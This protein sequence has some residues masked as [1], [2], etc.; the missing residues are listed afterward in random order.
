MYRKPLL[1]LG[2]SLLL[3]FLSRLASHAQGRPLVIESVVPL[4]F[5]TGDTIKIRGT[6][7]GNNPDNLC[8]KVN[9]GNG[10]AIPLMAVE[11]TDTEVLAVVGPVR[12]DTPG[13]I[14]VTPGE[15]ASGGGNTDCA[16]IL[17]GQNTWSWGPVPGLAGAAGRRSTRS[18]QIHRPM[19]DGSLPINRTTRSA[20]GFPS[21]GALAP[22]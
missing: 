2:A 21:T 15:G 12:D 22:R 11:V 18:R 6:G 19:C 20:C 16:G 14:E 7:F 10:T 13:V 3:V 17:G 8:A 4:Q 1:M 5:K 9:T